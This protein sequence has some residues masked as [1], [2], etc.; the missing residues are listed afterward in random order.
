MHDPAKQRRDPFEAYYSA[1][2]IAQRLF[3]GAARH[4]SAQVVRREIERRPELKRA[5]VRRF[6]RVFLPWSALK[7]WLE[8]EVDQAPGA[9][10]VAPVFARTQGELSRKLSE[11]ANG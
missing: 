4:V 3:T 6:G 1:E 11:V 2:A 9:V 7:A 5:A 10:F 8:V